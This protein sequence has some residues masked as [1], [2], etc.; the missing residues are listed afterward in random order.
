MYVYMYVS[1]INSAFSYSY[2]WLYVPTFG[3]YYAPYL[4][5]T[6]KVKT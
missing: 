1:V 4:L 5:V 2:C 6:V 3:Y